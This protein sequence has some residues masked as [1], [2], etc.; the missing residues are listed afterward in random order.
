VIIANGNTARIGIP[1]SEGDLAAVR[2]GKTYCARKEDGSFYNLK[3]PLKDA[4]GRPIGILVMELPFTSAPDEDH[5]IA[6]AEA[7]RDEL[8]LQITDYRRL[9]Q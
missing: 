3:L 9:F 7:I 2:A 5:A 4:S 1:S 6:K 8:S